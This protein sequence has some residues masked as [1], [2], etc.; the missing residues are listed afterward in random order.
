MSVSSCSKYTSF[1][2]PTIIE[3]SLV[4]V[5]TTSG[6]SV[7][8]CEDVLLS[9]G[10]WLLTGLAHYSGANLTSLSVS[11]EKNNVVQTKYKVVQT[12]TNLSVPFSVALECREASWV[13]LKAESTTS[14]GDFQL[15]TSNSNIRFVRIG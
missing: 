12:T 5:A 8:V 2:F 15:V 11:V 7:K 14:V 9:K 4:D 13:S 6:K 1:N 3:P 10:V